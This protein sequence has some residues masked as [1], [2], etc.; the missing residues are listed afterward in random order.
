[1]AFSLIGLTKKGARFLPRPFFIEHLNR[2]ANQFFVGVST[3]RLRI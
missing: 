2:R 1:M 3:Q